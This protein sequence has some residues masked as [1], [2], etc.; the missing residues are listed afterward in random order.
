MRRAN[1][2]GTIVKLS[3][4][5]R[6]P[7]AV[8]VPTRDEK[9]RVKQVY[10]SYHAKAGDAQEALDAYNK[11]KSAGQA[12]SADKLQ[13]TVQQIYDAWSARE[14]KKLNPPSIRSHKAAWNS[15]VSRYA[16]R[17]MRNVTLDEWQAILDEDEDNGLSQSTINNDALLIKDLYAYASKNDI[18]GKDYSKYLDIPSVDPKKAKGAFND[19]QMRKLE[20]MAAEGVPWADTVLILCYTGFRIT[21]FLGLTPFSYHPE[22]GGYLQA[23]IKSA[24]GRDRIVPVHPKIAP[25]LRKRLAEGGGTIISDH[26]MSISA[27]KYR[28]SIFPEIAAALWQLDATP[29][30]CR[31]TFATRL[32]TAQVDSLT[33]KW[34]LGHSTKGDVTAGY[35]HKELSVL[36]DAVRRLA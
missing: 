27:N 35:T 5:R 10:L 14:Y 11:L 3:G 29:H 1:G 26:G 28:S 8:R 18:V 15:R 17:K 7:Y 22:S 21:E 31:H 6:S 4:N 36:V 20:Q 33:T 19:L 16:E 12:P 25:Y 32:H 2:T 23:G 30:W 13:M 34:L 24:A 9:G